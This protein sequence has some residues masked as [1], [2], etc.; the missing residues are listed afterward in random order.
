MGDSPPLTRGALS[1]EQMAA[2]LAFANVLSTNGTDGNSNVRNV[3][4]SPNTA[5]DLTHSS[6]EPSGSISGHHN[7]RLSAGSDPYR[8]E[9]NRQLMSGGGS[10]TTGV[11]HGRNP[12]PLF[13]DSGAVGPSNRRGRASVVSIPGSAS[14]KM[15]E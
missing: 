4:P 2:V 14:K 7:R 12:S 3:Q 6:P 9:V 8:A 13:S 10:A 15:K 11:G 1:A 5:I